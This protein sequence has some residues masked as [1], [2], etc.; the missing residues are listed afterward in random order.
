MCREFGTRWADLQRTKP[1]L[2]IAAG[3]R[4][5]KSG[6]DCAG[7]VTENPVME[8]H[9]RVQNGLVVCD[10]G[11]SLP[12]AASVS[13]LYRAPGRAKPVVAL[14]RIQLPLVH[15]D[16]PGTVHLTGERIAEILDAEKAAPGCQRLSTISVRSD[17]GSK[18]STCGPKL[19]SQA[20]NSRRSPSSNSASN[21]PSR[22]DAIRE[23]LPTRPL[24]RRD[25]RPRAVDLPRPARG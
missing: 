13:V 4:D 20:F 19:S 21:E 11:V 17:S 16:Q 23:S 15:C 9:G 14:R 22:R 3:T 2:G 6:L 10:G 7:R 1:M 24:R 18:T 12:E 8:I 5:L 25:D